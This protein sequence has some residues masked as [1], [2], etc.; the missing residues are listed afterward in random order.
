MDERAGCMKTEITHIIELTAEEFGVMPKAI[1]GRNRAEVLCFARQAA[2]FLAWRHVGA[3]D[4]TLGYYFGKRKGS[5][6]L[7]ARKSV[8]T[9]LETNKA[10]R[11]AFM[12]IEEKI[13]L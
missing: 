10:F 5:A 1:V 8:P 12:N 9:L 3:A 6:I 2:M 13:N 7:Y 11:N 4:T